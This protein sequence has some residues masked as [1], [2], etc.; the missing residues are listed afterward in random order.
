MTA[1]VNTTK[2]EV[3]VK[4]VTVKLMALYHLLVMQMDI[5]VA[6]MDMMEKNVINVK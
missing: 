5:V 2:G 4:L 6:K 3:S 1:K